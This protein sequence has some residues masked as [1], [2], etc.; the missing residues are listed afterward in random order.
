VRPVRVPAV[1]AV[2][3]GDRPHLSAKSGR[4]TGQFVGPPRAQT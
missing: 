2:S 4:K 3:A 1:W